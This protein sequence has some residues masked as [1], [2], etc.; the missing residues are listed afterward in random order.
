MLFYYFFFLIIRRPPR[1][2]LFP[3][4]TLF[5][6]DF[7]EPELLVARNRAA[8]PVRAPGPIR[9]ARAA[10]NGEARPDRPGACAR[11]V[12]AGRFESPQRRRRAGRS[13]GPGCRRPQERSE[14]RRVA[15]GDRTRPT[16]G[17]GVSPRLVRRDAERGTPAAC[18][19]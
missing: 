19:P 6:S 11:A 9:R 14:A 13:K 1:S 17:R 15:V 4:T 10:Q 3:Y 2:T 16:C 8:P 18:A 7:G 5:R 12:D